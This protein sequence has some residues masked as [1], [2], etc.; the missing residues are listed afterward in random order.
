MK[1][2]GEKISLVVGIINIFMIYV[3]NF[4]YIHIKGYEPLP[5]EY[6]KMLFL[7]IVIALMAL[8]L[9]K[10]VKKIQKGNSKW[11]IGGM[12]LAGLQIM[13]GIIGIL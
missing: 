10:L 11:I 12:V 8:I 1:K 7:H 3:V 5:I 13:G 4:V 6:Y 9:A 2:V